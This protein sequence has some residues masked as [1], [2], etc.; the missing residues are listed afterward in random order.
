[1]A[2]AHADPKSTKETDDLTDFF[3]HLGST[4]VKTL[5]KMLTKLTPD[6]S[7]FIQVTILSSLINRCWTSQTNTKKEIVVLKFRNC[8]SPQKYKQ[9]TN[10]A[11]EDFFLPTIHN[12]KSKISGIAALAHISLFFSKL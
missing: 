1:M 2:I 9:Q 12:I 10:Y 11:A 5:R 3:A 6:A 8:L 7:A 4:H